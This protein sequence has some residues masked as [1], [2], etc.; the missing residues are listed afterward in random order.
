V[1]PRSRPPATGC[2]AE[3][4]CSSRLPYCC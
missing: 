3:A 4:R 1:Q 2:G